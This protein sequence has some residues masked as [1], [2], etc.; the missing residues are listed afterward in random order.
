VA[1]ARC[2]DASREQLD[3]AVAAARRA[4]VPWS[5]LS[6][7]ERRATLL[8]FGAAMGELIEPLAQLLVREQG[9][10]LAECRKELAFVPS[11]SVLVD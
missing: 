6:F 11:R 3:E 8:T 1:F 4:F 5:R 10:T 7:E 9:K 2:P